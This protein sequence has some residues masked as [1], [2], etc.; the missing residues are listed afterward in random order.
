LTRSSPSCS[1]CWTPQEA[2]SPAH[3]P[4]H[5]SDLPFSN[6]NQGIYEG[7]LVGWDVSASAASFWLVG[8]SLQLRL[9]C[10]WGYIHPLAPG[11]LAVGGDEAACSGEQK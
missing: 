8:A 10:C 4:S 1:S 11:P 9:S 2:P 6:S 7:R 5:Q 3:H